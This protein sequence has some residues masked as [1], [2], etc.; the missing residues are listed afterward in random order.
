[1]AQLGRK[2]LELLTVKEL[3]YPN[4]SVNSWFRLVVAT[5]IISDPS[6]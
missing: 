1:M 5:Q 6:G 2:V 4:L 3:K